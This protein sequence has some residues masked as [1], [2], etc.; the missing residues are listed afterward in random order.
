[1]RLLPIGC[2]LLAA[3]ATPAA[4]SPLAVTPW[5]SLDDQT[6]KPASTRGFDLHLPVQV[7][8]LEDIVVFDQHKIKPTDLPGLQPPDR[9]L[10]GTFN[11]GG[12]MMTR[13]ADC[14]AG[15]TTVAGQP[16]FGG[17]FAGPVGVSGCY[18]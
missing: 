12:D 2:A 9:S 14:H 7:P 11:A 3:A 6:R 15:Y 10:R 5:A 1:M 13:P 17:D 4:A 8:G 16:A 18:W